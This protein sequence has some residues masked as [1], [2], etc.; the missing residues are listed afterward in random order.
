[1]ASQTPA[2][3]PRLSFFPLAA[4]E[5]MGED[6]ASAIVRHSLEARERVSEEIRQ[7]LDTAIRTSGVRVPGGGFRPQTAHL[8]PSHHLQMPVFR[9]VQES[10]ELAGA[11]LRLWSASMSDLYE[12]VEE[13]LL[14][15]SEPIYGPDRKLGCF[16]SAWDVKDWEANRE[17]FLSEHDNFDR[18]DA[19]L[20]LWWVSG[21]MPI[22]TSIA[23]D[24]REAV[25]LTR[26]LE[27][28]K[29]LPLDAP[30]WG[31]AQQFITAFAEVI[32]DK[33]KE[34]SQAVVNVFQAQLLS[35][36]DRF[37]EDL[38]YLERDVSLWSS[39]APAP[40]AVAARMIDR[41]SQLESLLLQYSAVR[42]QAL[43]RSEEFERAQRRA[44]LESEIID[45]LVDVEQVLSGTYPVSENEAVAPVT[46]PESADMPVA[47]QEGADSAAAAAAVAKPIKPINPIESTEP[48][49]AVEPPVVAPPPAQSTPPPASTPAPAP[50]AQESA[51]TEEANAALLSDMQALREEMEYLRAELHSRKDNEEYWRTS[52]MN[53]Q[54][55]AAGAESEASEEPQNVAEA[56]SLAEKKFPVE[57]LFQLNSRSWVNRNNPFE[58]PTSVLA[59]LEWLATTYYRSRTGEISVPKLDDSLYEVCRWRYVSNQ[60]DV[61]MGQYPNHYQTKVD[62]KL[63]RLE[64]HIGRGNSKDAANTIRIAFHWDRENRRV[65]VGYIG[66][67]QRTDAT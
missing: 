16:R 35:I 19:G 18:K 27:L 48:A 21:K 46:A 50:V 32:A 49:A 13:Y 47:V 34:R 9:K 41:V 3:G 28:L 67:H 23:A 5:W 12:A 25:D 60:S 36:R 53:A 30:Q 6:Y 31:Q 51:A 17:Q 44:E 65:I 66:Q 24:V 1:M 43:V 54:R 40:P 45:V 63:Y 10:D 57:L 22:P 37:S 38:T 58:D 26:W 52:Y 59:A 8:A 42:D 14:T 7:A 61:T 39:P 4:Q 11:L 33:E 15:K 20:M 64:E 29:A 56:V 2:A 55:E 62:G